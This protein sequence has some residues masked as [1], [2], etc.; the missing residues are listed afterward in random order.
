MKSVG[1]R[2]R[3]EA[4]IRCVLAAQ[5]LSRQTLLVT[6][7]PVLRHVASMVACVALASPALASAP[8]VGGRAYL[9]EN[10]TTGDVVLAKNARQRVPIASITKLMT[11]L[12]TLEHA[13]LD[14]VVTVTGSAAARGE[15]S[16][17]LAPGERLTVRELVK[18]ALI[19]SA[20]DAAAALAD[21]VGRGSRSTFVSMMNAKARQ[22]G[23]RD[24]EF[25]NP[26]GLDAAGAYSS[27]RDVTRL[28]RVAMRNPTIR[29]IVSTTETTISGGRRLE[30]WNDLLYT[31][32]GLLG[33]KTGHTSGAGWSQVA[34]ARGPG[35]VVYATLLGEAT[36]AQ[37]NEDLTR[38]LVWGISRY[39][40]LPIV[41]Q[42]KT[43]ASVALP[44]GKGRLPLVAARDQL[45]VV[46]LG[47]PLI[48]E[49]VAPGA[50]TL[51]VGKGEAL[52]RVR[53]Y[54]EGRL[55]ASSPLVAPRAV[56]PPG[57]LGRVGWYA[58]ETVGNV[59]DFV[60]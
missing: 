44:Y 59:W 25:A 24:T 10:A 58:G 29:Q 37:R 13:R 19:Q 34:A 50:V 31:F 28:A 36:R 30:T 18:A 9:V 22:L 1:D 38:L 15:S 23:L 57:V 16:I 33:V 47:K 41:A 8:Q 56:D 12:V 6:S 55:I 42:G 60:N 11:V 39:R 7:A 26:D 2:G 14:D 5:S 54:R 46:R 20:N 45:R 21:H 53:V 27:A 49:V 51:P 3:R 35:F 48:E 32:P 40:K 4:A 52:G 17:Y 43:Y